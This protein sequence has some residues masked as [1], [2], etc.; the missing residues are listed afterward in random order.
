MDILTLMPHYVIWIS[1]LII[2]AGTINRLIDNQSILNFF[3]II[4]YKSAI[5]IMLIMSKKDIL[6]VPFQT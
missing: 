1:L 3:L 2:R 6:L 5:S 4:D